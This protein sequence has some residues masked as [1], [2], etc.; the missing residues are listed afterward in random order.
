[1]NMVYDGWSAGEMAAMYAV[2]SVLPDRQANHRITTGCM[3][4]ASLSALLQLFISYSSR[5]QKI[6]KNYS[7]LDIISHRTCSVSDVRIV[8]NKLQMQSES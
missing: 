8:H 5:Q 1:M 7:A 6:K 3:V 4:H 2:V